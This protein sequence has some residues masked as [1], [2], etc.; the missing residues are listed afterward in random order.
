M[1]GVAVSRRRLHEHVMVAVLA[2]ILGGEFGEGDLLPKETD[3]ASAHGVSRGVARES[4]LALQDRGV[5]TVRH[6]VGASVASQHQWQ[7]FDPTLLEALLNSPVAR[8]AVRELLEC[9]E[10]LWPEIAA[11]AAQRRTSEDVTRLAAAVEDHE[12]F[13]MALLDA[14]RN[15]FLRRALTSSHRA[16]QAV[17]LESGQD[18]PWREAVLEAVSRGDVGSAREASRSGALAARPYSAMRRPAPPGRAR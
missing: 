4:I 2:R 12:A 1:T 6:G 15:R 18:R 17:N 16:L 5:V 7:L 10:V 3:L 8:D 14:S 9:R 13:E 11:I